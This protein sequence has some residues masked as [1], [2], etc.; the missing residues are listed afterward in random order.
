[1]RDFDFELVGRRRGAHNNC[2]FAIENLDYRSWLCREDPVTVGLAKHF[3]IAHRMNRGLFDF[4]CKTTCPMSCGWCCWRNRCL[5]YENIPSDEIVGLSQGTHSALGYI[6]I[7]LSEPVEQ[8]I[9]VGTMPM[10]VSYLLL[11]IFSLI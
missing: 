4:R 1:M 2:I 6:I 10:P 7:E 11:F 8:V 3:L 9:I 5:N